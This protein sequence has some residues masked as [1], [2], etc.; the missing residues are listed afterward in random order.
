MAVELC[1]VN[2]E[3]LSFRNAEIYMCLKTC[4]HKCYSSVLVACSVFNP[5]V[6]WLP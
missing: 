6:L 5:C 1:A 4:M 3:L 2:S